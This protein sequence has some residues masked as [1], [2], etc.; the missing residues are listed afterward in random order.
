MD[1]FIGS[2][3]QTGRKVGQGQHVELRQTVL[4]QQGYTTQARGTQLETY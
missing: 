2:S 1:T 4:T 3:L